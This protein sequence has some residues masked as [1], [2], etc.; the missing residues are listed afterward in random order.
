M[1]THMWIGE[2]LRIPIS[3]NFVELERC[4]CSSQLRWRSVAG[5]LLLSRKRRWAHISLPI[6]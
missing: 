6:P 3:L 4:P 2:W 5:H 1:H